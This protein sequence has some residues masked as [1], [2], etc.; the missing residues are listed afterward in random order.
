MDGTLFSSNH[1][2]KFGISMMEEVDDGRD[3]ERV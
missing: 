1:G 3:N 2:I